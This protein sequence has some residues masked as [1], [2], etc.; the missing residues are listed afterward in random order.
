MKIL[1]AAE[2]A[3]VDRRTVEEFGVSYMEDRT[4]EEP[5]WL[6]FATDNVLRIACSGIPAKKTSLEHTSDTEQGMF[7]LPL[8]MTCIRAPR[9]H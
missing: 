6:K 4:G 5:T 8:R 1:A 3:E 9:A 2:M 7:D